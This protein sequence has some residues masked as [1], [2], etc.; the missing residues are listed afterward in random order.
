MRCVKERYGAQPYAS[1]A[2]PGKSLPVQIFKRSRPVDVH[3]FID[4][5]ASE[6]RGSARNA[7]LES[8]EEFANLVAGNPERLEEEPSSWVAA[9]HVEVRLIF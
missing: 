7:A 5:E 1:A 9:V 6:V 4:N 8:E 3:T 2:K